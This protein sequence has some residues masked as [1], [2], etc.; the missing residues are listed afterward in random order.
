MQRL[1]TETAEGTGD[2]LSQHL[3]GGGTEE[4]HE[5]DRLCS[6]KDIM[7][8]RRFYANTFPRKCDSFGNQIVA[9][10]LTHISMEKGKWFPRD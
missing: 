8:C 2:T 9:T 5:K 7:T 10:K 4:N 3:P 1:A 6:G